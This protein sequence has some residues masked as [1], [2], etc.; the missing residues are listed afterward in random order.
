MKYIKKNLDKQVNLTNWV[1]GY[2]WIPGRPT[3]SLF[4]I[5]VYS[6][7]RSALKDMGV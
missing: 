5:S 3:W 1:I 2:R 7:S 6:M 4:T